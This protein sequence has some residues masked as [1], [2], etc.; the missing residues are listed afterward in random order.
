M[1]PVEALEKDRQTIVSTIAKIESTRPALGIKWK[2]SMLR[3]WYE[4]LA[5][6][7]LAVGGV[8]YDQEAVEELG[9]KLRSDAA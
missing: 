5:E 6:L 9:R 8:D 3:Y 2:D 1:Q 4:R 7:T